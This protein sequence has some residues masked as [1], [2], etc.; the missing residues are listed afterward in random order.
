MPR[1]SRADL[2]PGPQTP[3]AVQSFGWWARPVAY[4]E[5]CRR[6]FGK[7]FTI[8][9]VG[10][11]PFVII[12]DPAE[13]KQAFTAPPEILHP[14]EGAQI[15][16]PIV[17]DNSILLLDEGEHLR[18]RRLVLPAF[19]G[20]RIER[21]RELVEEVTARE[22]A[23]WPLGH[24][25]ASQE[26]MQRLTMEV[27]LR[28]VFGLEPGERLDRLRASL[29]GMTKFG[30]SPISLL[31]PAQRSIA[32]RGPWARFKA[33]RDEVDEITYELIAER[34]ADADLD[35]ADILS[36]FA[37]ATH[38]DGSPMTDGEIRDQLMTLMIAGHETT[39]TSLAW[40]MERLSR[41]PQALAELT[42][43]V[44]AGDDD[45]YLTA[46]VR[47]VM[48][49]RPVLPVAQPRMTK[50]PIEVGGWEYP[51]GVCL[52]AGAWLVHHDAEIY[53]DPYAFKPERFLDTEPGTYTWIPFG[54]GRRRCAGANLA[55]LEMKAVL[56]E[57]LR[58]ADIKSTSKPLEPI[59][60][61]AITIS[62]ASGGE[63]TLVARVGDSIGV[64][65]T[66]KTA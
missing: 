8:R 10:Q 20:D 63:V 5:R 58:V 30:L 47:E 51:V 66:V 4:L 19:G 42:A 65:R 2:P 9:Q 44:R 12:S 24:S 1:V 26:P 16:A 33:Y 34:R 25:I 40:A 45:T 23:S 59:R 57:L 53:P 36:A 41:S 50:A 18:Q 11:P 61:R 22:I 54:G 31:P 17:G 7:R 48:R 27:I 38:E 46:T 35:A 62:P 64:N 29:T 21:L 37:H 60:R 3:A 13:I 6:Q 32:G 39:A 43:E 55:I 52:M 49:V 15:L 56:R 28:A 14:G